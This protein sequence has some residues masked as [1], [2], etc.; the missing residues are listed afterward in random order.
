MGDESS[1]GKRTLRVPR[2]RWVDNMKM[3]LREM[4]WSGVHWIHLAQDGN[5][6]RTLTNKLMN[7]QIP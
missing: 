7:L 5:Q 4:G 1:A 3:D 2:H 6:W